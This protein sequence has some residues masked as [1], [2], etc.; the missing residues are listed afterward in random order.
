MNKKR[1]HLAIKGIL[2]D[3]EWIENPNRVKS[4]LYSYYSNLFSAPDMVSN[5]EIKKAVWDCGS[6]KS[7]R[8]DGFTFEFFKKF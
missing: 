5:E 8:P 7:P 2:V 1:R 3:G 6:D 4:K